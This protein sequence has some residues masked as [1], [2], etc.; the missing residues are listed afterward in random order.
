[1]AS[2]CFDGAAVALIFLGVHLENRALEGTW[3]IGLS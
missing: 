3:K 1:L 2:F